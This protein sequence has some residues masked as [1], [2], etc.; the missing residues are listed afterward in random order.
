ML[1]RFK[2]VTGVSVTVAEDGIRSLPSPGVSGLRTVEQALALLLTGT[3]VGYRFTAADAVVVEVRVNSDTV[4]VSGA[5]PH[6]AA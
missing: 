6:C 3:G 4:Q 1:E 5:L 2:T